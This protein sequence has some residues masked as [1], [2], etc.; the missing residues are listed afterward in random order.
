[1]IAMARK[2]GGEGL[3]VSRILPMEGG[4]PLQPTTTV[5]TIT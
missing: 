1:M 3:S 5:V 4:G 2:E